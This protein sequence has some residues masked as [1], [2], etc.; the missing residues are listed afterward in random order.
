MDELTVVPYV[1]AYLTRTLNT[2]PQVLLIYRSHTGFGNNHYS[3]AGGKINA[4]ESP[5][6][7]LIRELTEELAI[8]VDGKDVTFRTLLYFEGATRT[9]VAFLF[10]VEKWEKEPINN[11]PEKHD[12]IRWFD[13]SNLPPTLLPRHRILIEQLNK[14]VLYGDVGFT[15]TREA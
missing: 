13:L 11:E 5:T 6:E 15:H 12:H 14:E 7:A 2:Q 9:C 4:G 3:L 1:L 8:E 10:S